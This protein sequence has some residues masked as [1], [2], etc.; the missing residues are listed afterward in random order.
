ME[1]REGEVKVENGHIIVENA[2][3]RIE[4]YTLSGILMES[5]P[6]RGGTTEIHLPQGIY[7][8]KA[9]GETVKVIL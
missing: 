4:V 6:A 7:I 2:Q 8:V 5:L 3:G 1:V 9:G